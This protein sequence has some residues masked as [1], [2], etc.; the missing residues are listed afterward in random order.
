MMKK[1]CCIVTLLSIFTGNYATGYTDKYY[2]IR[3]KENKYEIYYGDPDF[4]TN[5][6]Y[7][8]SFTREGYKIYKGSSDFISHLEY[9]IMHTPKGYRIYNGDPDFSSNLVF[10]IASENGC[11]TI[12]KGSEDFISHIL[13]AIK[14]RSGEYEVYKGDPDFSSNKIFSIEIDNRRAF[15]HRKSHFSPESS[16]DDAHTGF[17]TSERDYHRVLSDIIIYSIHNSL[18]SEPLSSPRPIFRD[19]NYSDDLFIDTVLKYLIHSEIS[20]LL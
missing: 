5:L 11:C 2:N 7:T 19:A 14:R 10:S 18:L 13:Y 9:A 1:L 12:Y 6:Q 15:S 3:I 16:S 4:S 20:K 8:I 17:R